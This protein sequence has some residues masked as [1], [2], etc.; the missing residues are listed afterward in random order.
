[1]DLSSTLTTQVCRRELA[2][3]FDQDMVQDA[4][5]II[6]LPTRH[7]AGA[8]SS[9]L[10]NHYR[11]WETQTLPDPLRTPDDE[12][13][14][15]PSAHL[16][17]L[18][19]L[20]GRLLLFIEDYL[21]KATATDPSREY[22]GLSSLSLR[23]TYL[24]YVGHPLSPRFSA[25]NLTSPERQRFFRAFLRY[26]LLCKMC[27]S[28]N[29]SDSSWYYKLSS[30]WKYKGQTFQKVEAEAIACV[31][32][33]VESL[34]KAISIQCEFYDGR[35]YVLTLIFPQLSCFGFDLAAA[36][37]QAV[38]AGKQGR[39]HVQMWYL[40][41]EERHLGDLRRSTNMRRGAYL[42]RGGTDSDCNDCILGF[43]PLCEKD[44]HYTE[45]PGMYKMLYPIGT[46]SSMQ[47]YL[48]RRK[49]WAFLDD[50]RLH[51]TRLQQL[52]FTDADW[53]G[54]EKLRDLHDRPVDEHPHNAQ[55]QLEYPTPP[56]L[57][58]KRFVGL[59]PFWQ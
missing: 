49:A 24:T 36:L 5:A 23:S 2:A 6:L 34:H 21:T 7:P 30:L 46:S 32:S 8:F 19:R 54:P 13:D 10:R 55:M 53:G 14:A 35:E 43:D 56:F 33:Y 9:P 22:F 39:D 1:M 3:D 20:H 17:R 15:T 37:L 44:E 47:R 48:Y 27:C 18:Y 45:G 38:T 57:Q 4:M 58:G 28:D 59:A 31:Q 50:I 25:A 26:E 12:C 40:D 52:C 11:L 16:V 41:L 51:P 29:L 42:I